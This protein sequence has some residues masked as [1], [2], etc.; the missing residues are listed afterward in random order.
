M[1]G[2]PVILDTLGGLV[3]TARPEEIPEG[4]SPR[5]WDTDFIVGRFIQ[6]PGEQS[7]YTYSG[8]QFGPSG[9]GS[10]VDVSLGGSTWNSPTN[11]LVNV[12]TYANTVLSASANISTTQGVRT[13]IAPFYVSTLYV[14]FTAPISASTGQVFTFSGLTT[15]TWL[16]GQSLTV[17]AIVSSTELQFNVSFGVV[18]FPGNYGPTAD[19]G[20]ASSAGLNPIS[21]GLNVTQFGFSLPS[22]DTPQ[23][24]VISF[25]GYASA[26][27][28]TLS[29]QMIKGGVVVGNT[30]SRPVGTSPATLTF[31]GPSDLFGQSWLYSDIDSSNFGVQI[32]AIATGGTATAYVG[33]VTI[34]VF[35]APAQAN[36]LGIMD[37]D[38]EHTDQVTLALD[39]NGVTWEEDVTNNPKVLTAQSLIPVATGGSYLK[40]VDADGTAYMAYSNLLTGT[41]Q[42]MQFNGQWCDRITQV[43]PGAP[44][45]F[46]ASE[47][48]GA[49]ASVTAYSY[50]GGILTL[51]A[52]NTFTAGELVSFIGFTGGCAPLNGLTFS[53]LGTG[54]SGSQFE[55]ATSLVSGSGSDTGFATPQYSYPIQASATG[56]TQPAAYSDP[57][58]PGHLSVL[59]WS[60]GPGSTTAGNVLTVYYQS[61]FNYPTPDET[62]VN[63][64]TAGEPVYVYISGAPFGN[65]TWQVTSIG[66]ALPPGVAHWRYYFTVQLPSSAYQNV[67]EPT[68]QYQISQATVTL[69]TAAPGLAPGDQVSLSGVTNSAWDQTYTIVQALNSGSFSISQTSLTAGTATYSWALVTGVAP[70]AG[71]LVTVTGTLNANGLLNVTNALIV[72]ASGVSSGTFT[73]AGLP[74]T[75]NYPTAVETGQATTAGTQFIIDPGAAL[76]NT[77]TQSPILGNSGGGVLNVVG[78]A[79]GG[80]FPIGA[81]TRQGVV[82]FITRNGATTKPSPPATFTVTLGSNYITA[83][84]IPIGPPN[85]VARGIAFTEA[86]QNG[87]PG[88]NFYTY[89][90]PVIFTVAGV[91]FTAS[92]LI[93]PDNVTTTMKFTF[94]DAVLL[95]SD[96]IDI[97]GNNYFNFIELGNP[98][99]MFQYANRMLYG[100]CQTKVQNFLNLSFDGGYLPTNNYGLPQP[101]G[102]N[103]TTLGAAQ[104]YSITGFQITSNVVTFY[105]PNSLIAGAQVN[106]SGLS[107][108]TYLNGLTLT[109]ISAS[110]NSFTASFTHANVT[111]TTD[112][113]IA[114]VVTSNA[115]LV[116]SPAFGNSLVINNNTSAT[117]S[118]QWY[119]FQS[120]YQ[121]AYNVNILQ[122]NTAYSVRVTARALTAVAQSQI[123]VGLVNYSGGVFGTVLALEAFT[124]AIG[125]L[126]I[127]TAALT[128]GA[129]VVPSVLQLAVGIANLSSGGSVE[130]DRVEIFPTDRPIDTTTIWC[131]YAGEG[132]QDFEAVDGITGS[133]G[134]GDDNPQ[135]CQGAYEINTQLF[136]EKLKSCCVTQDSPNYEPYRWKVSL[137]SNSVGAAGPNAFDSQE[138]FSLKAT[139]S[140]IYFFDGGKPS[141]ISRELQSTG[142]QGSI[143]E[144]INWNAG[145]TIWLRNDT[146]LRRVLIGV[147]MN[148]P[149][150]WLPNAA[151]ATPTSP[152]VIIMLNYTGCPTAEELMASVPVHTTMFGDLK[153]LDMR[154][155]WSIWQ[156]KSPIA[157]FIQRP[158]GFTDELLLAN[159]ISNSKI[160]KLVNGAPSGGQNTD[161][162]AAISWLYTTYGFTKAKQGQQMP[163]LGALRKV[164]YYFAA[165]MEGVGQV[166]RKFLS[167]SLGAETQ[168]TYTAPNATLAYPQQNDQEAVLEIGGQRLF[169]QFSSV[170][171]GGYAEVGTI[172][173]DGEMDKNSPHRGVS[174]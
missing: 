19:T 26:T 49:Q 36:Y 155:K 146:R 151:A 103:A 145:K 110:I 92:A 87:V 112:A 51:T 96:E 148:T 10:A 159:G 105:A 106:I 117:I 160:Y 102:W 156:I 94:S 60:N 93:V 162:G 27:G 88:A 25:P 56:I 91:V 108:G 70:V 3:A 31:G 169:I 72:S 128:T 8:S 163:G 115:G 45:T 86:G 138:E 125:G 78:Q 65:G 164:W 127:Q 89:D 68:G 69:L 67:V 172:M 6:R 123:Q 62:L 52:T 158:D 46:T 171:S 54:L 170:G 100:L 114:Q 143:W 118:N 71:Q 77:T 39:S 5:T 41:S 166:G 144:T 157:E 79:S 18:G 21:D 74:S 152:N 154:R 80:T 97:E 33:Y 139:R 121:D 136:I 137:S 4:A 142:T 107:V 13:G 111:L 16:N 104:Q 55:I 98:A 48:A 17:T 75:I 150:F 101:L 22:T 50:S 43:G 28:V 30:E 66:N 11:V 116:P 167:N 24:L 2:Q 40:G 61:S 122:P 84:N 29:V 153:A 120:A 168:N 140:G 99:W 37:A 135:P 133:L 113:G 129:S 47:Q 34:E 38:L 23:G 83:S 95:S 165:T 126:V 119:Y 20:Q 42:P 76:V 173:L 82:F 73:V 130:I 14:V 15:E 85:V 58:D 161:D 109:V 147:P 44:P 134:C 132:A 53:V 1:P 63:A 57:G 90:V 124:V 12:G 59:L 174:S 141:P 9:G 149:N 81:G 7:E 32:T 64:F 131:S 35:C